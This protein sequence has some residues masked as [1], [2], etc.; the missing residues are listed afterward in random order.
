MPPQGE[1]WEERHGYA[2]EIR[3]VADWIVGH[4]YGT[5]LSVRV[6]AEHI[7][8]RLRAEADRAEAGE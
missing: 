3:A 2:A 1:V 6:G 5:P 8:E 4:Y 7:I